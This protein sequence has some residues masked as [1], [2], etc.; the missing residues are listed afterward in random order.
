[1]IRWRTYGDQ[2][3]AR[4][5]RAER[6]DDEQIRACTIIVESEW[7]PRHRK[8]IIGSHAAHHEAQGRSGP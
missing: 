6:R 4:V 1:M 5:S 3:E 8:P 2:V 7:K